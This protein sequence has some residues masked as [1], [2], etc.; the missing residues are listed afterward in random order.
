[1]FG[2]FEKEE[3]K[4]IYGISTPLQS[5]DLVAGQFRLCKILTGVKSTPGFSNKM[6]VMFYGPSWRPGKQRLGDIKDIPEPTPN[7]PK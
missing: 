1:M 2:T 6:K 5:W 3:E 7:E 4:A